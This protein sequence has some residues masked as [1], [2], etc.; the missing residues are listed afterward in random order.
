MKYIGE[1]KGFCVVMLRGN[2]NEP[3]SELS[4]GWRAGLDERSLAAVAGVL[5][6]FTASALGSNSANLPEDRG[7]QPPLAATGFEVGENYRIG[8]NVGLQGVVGKA[9][10][11]GGRLDLSVES[12]ELID[13]PGHFETEKYPVNVTGELT[14]NVQLMEWAEAFKEDPMAGETV[15]DAEGVKKLI[16][17]LEEKI[18]E[19]WTI[20]SIE[21]TGHASDEDDRTW[22]TGVPGAG[23]G[24]DNPKNVELAA[25]RAE[26]VDNILRQELEDR[27]G[28]QA[29]NMSTIV[30]GGVEERDDLLNAAIAE[31]AV[32]RGE[33]VNDMIA[34]YNRGYGQFSPDE[35]LVLDQLASDRFVSIDVGISRE[36]MV[37]QGVYVPPE[38]I[39]KVHKE[40]RSLVFIPIIIPPGLLR[41]FGSRNSRDRSE[42]GNQSSTSTISS[43]GH[44]DTLDVSRDQ[45]DAT[46]VK[47]VEDNSGALDTTKLW[48]G[49]VSS[50]KPEDYLGLL[51]MI[52]DR[53]GVRSAKRSMSNFAVSGLWSVGS[54]LKHEDYLAKFSMVK[55]GDLV[56]SSM[57]NGGDL[58]RSY[59]PKSQD[60]LPMAKI[61]GDYKISGVANGRGGTG[62]SQDSVARATTETFKVQGWGPILAS[63][64]AASAPAWLFRTDSIAEN[65]TT[66]LPV[67]PPGPLPVISIPPRYLPSPNSVPSEA[68]GKTHSGYNA[69]AKHNKQP[70]SLNEGTRRGNMSRE[71]RGGRG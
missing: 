47:D 26:E 32:A 11:P 62:S 23:L 43:K 64:P 54:N 28:E 42:A 5:L 37:I 27:F 48:Y 44:S 46:F 41:R 13:V 9:V 18:A 58:M 53:G 63:T 66:P 36:E 15:D 14:G 24:V 22:E 10:L 25:R 12:T 69:T 21:L 39:E 52:R 71:G 19:G 65:S 16:D 51:D 31:L 49:A 6:T 57:I 17:I 38:T 3:S 33:T 34:A 30:V 45:D 60:V 8:V 7:T 4:G 2:N 67:M 35:L 61:S 50:E 59:M 40:K 56:K 29:D 55:W 68:I 1:M 20:D 70:T